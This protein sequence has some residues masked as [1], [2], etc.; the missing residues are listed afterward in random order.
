MGSWDEESVFGEEGGS[1]QGYPGAVCE[2]QAD[3]FCRIQGGP[4]FLGTDMQ[5]GFDDQHA[6]AGPETGTQIG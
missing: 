3:L 1:A 6:A 2:S 4:E 5:V